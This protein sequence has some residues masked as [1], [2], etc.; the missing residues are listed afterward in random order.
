MQSTQAHVRAIGN[1]AVVEAT[2]S[3]FSADPNIAAVSTAQ[4]NKFNVTQSIAQRSVTLC[5]HRA[6]WLEYTKAIS[7]GTMGQGVLWLMHAQPGSDAVTVREI[8]AVV[9]CVTQLTELHVGILMDNDSR[10]SFVQHWDSADNATIDWSRLHIFTSVTGMHAFV[11]SRGHNIEHVCMVS[12]PPGGAVQDMFVLDN[13][14]LHAVVHGG[15]FVYEVLHEWPMAMVHN[16]MPMLAAENAIASV[17]SRGGAH[18]CT[19][20]EIQRQPGSNKPVRLLYI[21]KFCDNNGPAHPVEWLR[22]L[23]QDTEATQ[24]MQQDSLLLSLVLRAASSH[25]DVPPRCNARQ[26]NAGPFVQPVVS[27][28]LHRSVTQQQFHD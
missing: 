25:S 22:S 24:C 13:T 18:T 12:G 23:V 6:A 7:S 10:A 4:D 27:P 9:A 14:V 8:M 21:S 19:T 17:Q 2:F 28:H 20:V 5:R 26:R 1:G 16:D 11:A 15:S 3:S